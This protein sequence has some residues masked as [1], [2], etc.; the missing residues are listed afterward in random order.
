MVWEAKHARITVKDQSGLPGMRLHLVV[1]RDN[2]SPRPASRTS[3][4]PARTQKMGIP[5]KEQPFTDRGMEPQIHADERR[6]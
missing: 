3:N 2:A 4:K 6:Q 1:A 5:L